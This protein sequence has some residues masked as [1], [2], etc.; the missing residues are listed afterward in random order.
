MEEKVNE[1]IYAISNPLLSG[2]AIEIDPQK[3]SG[4]NQCI[5]ACRRDVLIPNPE[6]GGPPLVLYPDECWYC[7][8]C[9]QECGTEAI[10]LI[11]PLYQRIAVIWKRKDTGELYYLKSP[12]DNKSY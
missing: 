10:N 5:E 6:K 8:C 9:V 1:N 2:K 11:Y 4:C 12:R 3:C 7:G